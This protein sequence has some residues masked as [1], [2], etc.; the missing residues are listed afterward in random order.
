MLSLFWIICIIVFVWFH[1]KQ[2]F[3]LFFNICIVV[4]VFIIIIIIIAIFVKPRK[5]QKLI[6]LEMT[7]IITT[8]IFFNN[9]NL[10]ITAIV[11]IQSK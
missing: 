3:D 10:K 9:S 6:T 8:A 7:G 4:V 1:H 5:D 11:S 2:D